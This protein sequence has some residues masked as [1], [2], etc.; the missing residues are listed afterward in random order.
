VLAQTLF[1]VAMIAVIAISAVAG[2]AGYARAEAAT[3]AKAL[4]QPAI[5]AAL[6]RYETT[7]VAPAIAA[8]YRPG[9]GSAAPAVAAPL[10]GGAPWSVQRYVLAPDAP[11]PLGATVSVTPTSTSVPACLPAGAS[12]N[13]GPDVENNGQCSN[14]VQESRLSVTI[15]AEVGPVSGPTGVAPLAHGVAT[16]T[17][18]LFAQPPFVMVAGVADDPAPGDPHEGDAG[19]FGNALGAFGPSPAP[20]DTTI[21]VVYACTP[22]LGD[23][24]ASSPLPQDLPTTLPW[25]NGNVS[26]S[27]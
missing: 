4:V 9:D 1:L 26:S 25:T 11:S 6:A 12:V 20:D 16:I 13:A 22:A 27:S 19:G 3:V 5:D 14:F 21:H 24:S 17:L 8:A 18:R 10:N 7:I 23:C 15:D 2:I